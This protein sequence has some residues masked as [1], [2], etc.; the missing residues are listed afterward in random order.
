MHAHLPAHEVIRAT[1]SEVVCICCMDC[2]G[3][4]WPAYRCPD[5]A[6]H[7]PSPDFGMPALLRRRRFAEGLSAKKRFV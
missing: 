5:W 4:T 3:R 2:D 1:V 7:S 6:I